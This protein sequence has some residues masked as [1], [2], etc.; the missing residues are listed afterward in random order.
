MTRIS[1]IWLKNKNGFFSFS[2]CQATFENDLYSLEVKALK[3]CKCTAP[4]I[5]PSKIKKL[6]KIF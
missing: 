1:E 5:L 6:S 3:S 2:D 4:R